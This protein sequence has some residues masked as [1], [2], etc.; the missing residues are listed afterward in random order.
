M[1]TALWDDIK[2][3]RNPLGLI[4]TSLWALTEEYAPKNT[5]I[6][7]Q[8]GAILETCHASFFSRRKEPGLQ[9]HATTRLKCKTGYVEN[10]P[11]IVF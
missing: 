9:K 5:Q 8:Q 4:F 3:A 7:Q 1:T 10:A 6:Q 2:R 11:F